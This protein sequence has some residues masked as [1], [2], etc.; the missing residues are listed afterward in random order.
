[1]CPSPN[2]RGIHLHSPYT[3][4]LVQPR[5]LYTALDPFETIRQPSK[6]S[7]LQV[8]EMKITMLLAALFGCSLA[9]PSSMRYAKRQSGPSQ[10][11]VVA[12]IDN[13][14]NDVTMVNSFLNTPPTTGAAYGSLAT[15]TL[16]FAQDEPNELMILSMV[17]G[18]PPDATSAIQNLMQVFGG[19]LSNLQ[20]IINNQNNLSV[21]NADIANINQIRCCHVL[22]D[23]DALW[24]GAADDEGVSNLVNLVVPRPNACATLTC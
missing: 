4:T 22:P 17:T 8:S 13:W 9:A 10:D 19:V 23:L 16:G 21:I 3:S 2:E 12:A 18:L 6:L 20:D 11:Q 24:Q 5:T 14:S 1:V 7:T 15:M